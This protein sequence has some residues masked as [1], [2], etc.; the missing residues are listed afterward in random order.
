M[1]VDVRDAAKAELAINSDIDADAPWLP[2]F[3]SDASS[4]IGWHV[5]KGWSDISAPADY[6]YVNDPSRLGF[7]TDADDDR[8]ERGQLYAVSDLNISERQSTYGKAVDLRRMFSPLQISDQ[9]V[10]IESDWAPSSFDIR[11]S[12]IKALVADLSRS[13]GTFR[14]L[15]NMSDTTPNYSLIR[16]TRYAT[17]TGERQA[18]IPTQG[19]VFSHRSIHNDLRPDY[20]VNVVIR[21]DVS[22]TR[23]I[24]QDVVFQVPALSLYP[25][26]ADFFGGLLT[27]GQLSM[28]ENVLLGGGVST[29]LL[30]TSLSPR[31]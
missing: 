2:Y 15:L 25:D 3:Q 30:Y 28:R 21:L 26:Q 5:R 12:R 31:D 22:R 4:D 17:I 10:S 27:S 13:D 19:N 8:F 6:N 14:G 7:Q 18:I 9:K 1:M 23:L 20:F 29:C 11:S 24:L 16:E